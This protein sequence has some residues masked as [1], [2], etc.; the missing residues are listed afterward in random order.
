MLESLVSSILPIVG[1]GSD[2]RRSR[3]SHSRRQQ[4]VREDMGN[5]IWIQSAET[6]RNYYLYA[7]KLFELPAKPDR[8]IVKTCADSRYKLYVNGKYIGKGPVR[9][10]AGCSYYDTYDITELLTKGKNVIAFHITYFG[11]STSVCVLRKPGLICRAEIE[12]GD[13]QQEIV[14]DQT[15]KVHR[16]SDWTDQGARINENL[17]F[18]EIYDSAERLDGWNEIKFKEK[19]WEEACIVGTAPTM[20]WGRLIERGIPQLYEEK[21]LPASIV[22]LYN[23]PDQNKETAPQA[24]PEI[25]AASE[26][27]DLTAGSVKHP[28]ALLTEAGSAQVKTP[29]GDRGVAVILDF[30]REVFGNIEIGIGGSGSGTIDIGYSETLEDGRVKPTRGEMKYTDRVVLKKGQLDWQSFEPRAFRYMQIEFRRCSRTVTL[31]YIRVNQTTYPVELIGDF[32]CSDNLLNDIWRIGAYTAKLC[33]EDTFID[34]P[35]QSRSQWWADARIESRTAYYAFD[36]VKLLAQGLR[37]IADTQDRS[38]AIMGIYPASEDK[39]VPDFALNWVFSILDYYAFSDDAGLVRDLYPNVRRLMDWFARYQNDFGLIGEVPGWIF[40]DS[41]DLERRGVLTSLNCLYYQALRVTA[42]LAAIQGKENESEDYGESAR[43]LRLAINKYLYSSDKGLYADCLIDGKLADKFSSQTNILA[44]LFDIP[45]HYSK[46]AIIRLLMGGVMP[47]I[48]TPYFTSHMLEV[49]YSMDRH[50]EALDIMRKKWGQ[51]VKSGEGT[52]PEFFGDDGSRCHGWSTGPTRDLIAEYVGIKPILGMHRFSVTPH[53]GDLGWARGAVAT[54][55]GLLAVEWRS[56]P[57]SFTIEAQVPDGLKVDVYPPCPMNTKVTVNGKAHPSCLVTLGGGKHTV[58]VTAVRPAKPK[59]L[60]KLPKPVPI[61]LVELLDDLSA[62]ARRSLG[63]TTSRHE[64]TGAKRSRI[65]TSRRSKT[66]E[67]PVEILPI[68]E[69]DTSVEASEIIPEIAAVSEVAPEA[70]AKTRRRRSHRGGRGRNKPAPEETAA[71]Q[72]PA[73]PAAEPMSEQTI[74]SAQTVEAGETQVVAA[75][76]EAPK[77]PSRRRSRRGGRRRS[78]RSP[79][80]TQTPAEVPSEAESVAEPVSD[81]IPEPIEIQAPVDTAAETSAEEAP[82]SGRRRSHRGGRRRSAAQKQT[83]PDTEAQPM[84][85][86]VAETV[87]EPAPE[88]STEEPPKKKR[89]TYTR[90]PRKKPS[91]DAEKTNSSE[92]SQDQP[93]D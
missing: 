59:P 30:G 64:R 26:L 6:T 34:S 61:P 10:A 31:D 63:L 5:W 38:G 45:D 70:E 32:E 66:E 62:Q 74:I 78:S 43:K 12:T 7:R 67:M 89:R 19:G 35:W 77:K 79:E 52:F 8:A 68:P 53:E 92:T 51:I 1:A 23:S 37:Q 50:K 86:P 80:E 69:L 56:T 21:V 28:E 40:I 9:S 54:R 57:R 65:K 87:P 16:A 71:A 17:G 44:A 82:K 20:P 41:A 29:R 42:I 76:E 91:E 88:A 3:R 84:V 49:F 81:Q 2:P 4:T 73:E 25:M 47:E 11:E 93:A 39:L 18:Q 14:T 85:E 75:V 46:A 83:E 48:K 55:T 15:W 27:V 22:G 24:V 36:D 72:V 58:K 60:D 33:M 13:Q 90:R